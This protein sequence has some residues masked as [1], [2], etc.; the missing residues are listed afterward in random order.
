MVVWSKHFTFGACAGDFKRKLQVLSS[1]ERDFVIVWSASS[2]IAFDA[3]A[4]LQ[5]LRLRCFL[6]AR[7]RD[8]SATDCLDREET[9]SNQNSASSKQTA[10]TGETVFV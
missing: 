6:C 10:T 1:L 8:E 3:G 9:N 5:F 4:G 2:E 7:I